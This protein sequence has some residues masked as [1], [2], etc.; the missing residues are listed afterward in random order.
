MYQNLAVNFGGTVDGKK[1]LQHWSLH[2]EEDRNGV[3]VPVQESVEQSQVGR[4]RNAFRRFSL[5]DVDDLAASGHHWSPLALHLFVEQD[6]TGEQACI[7]HVRRHDLRH[8]DRRCHVVDAVRR[9]VTFLAIEGPRV[10]LLLVP[11]IV[12]GKNLNILALEVVEPD[13][14]DEAQRVRVSNLFLNGDCRRQVERRNVKDVVVSVVDVVIVAAHKIGHVVQFGVGQV[15][16]C[17]AGGFV[18]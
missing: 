18:A 13:L 14:P 1:V 8:L 7:V 15:G 10:D 6:E 9:A 3:P 17:D 4:V 2:G 12:L 16:R 5:D 11:G